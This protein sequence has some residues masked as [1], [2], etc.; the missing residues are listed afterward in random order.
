MTGHGKDLAWGWGDWGVSS[1]AAGGNQWAHGNG[2]LPRQGIVRL[3]G[4]HLVAG[5]ETRDCTPGLT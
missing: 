4:S 5:V 3:Q 2:M 1:Q